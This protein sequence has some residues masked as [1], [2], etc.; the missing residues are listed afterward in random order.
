M[1]IVIGI[2]SIIL[3]LSAVDSLKKS[4]EDSIASWEVMWFLWVN[5]PGREHG[6]DYPWWKYIEPS[7]PGAW[8]ILKI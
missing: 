8:R 6:P 7:Q 3:V 1:G 4:V 2:Y 5:G